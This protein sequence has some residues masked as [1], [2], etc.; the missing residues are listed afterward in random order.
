MYMAPEDLHAFYQQIYQNVARRLGIEEYEWKSTQE[1]ADEIQ[2]SSGRVARKVKEFI[3]AY[4]NWFEVHEQIEA[5]RSSGSL[6]VDQNDRLNK[7][8]EDRDSI[9][10]ALINELLES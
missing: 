3:A 6:S 10:K 2:R 7:A 8:I 1:L 5:T 9:R 4:E